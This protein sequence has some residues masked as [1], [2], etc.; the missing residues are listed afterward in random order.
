MKKVSGLDLLNRDYS[1]YS[2]ISNLIEIKLERLSFMLYITSH[3]NEREIVLD[4]IL[5]CLHVG[6]LLSCIFSYLCFSNP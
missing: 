2:N 4:Q 3:I 6:F 1:R 5:T